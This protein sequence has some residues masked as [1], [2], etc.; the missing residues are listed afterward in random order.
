MVLKAVRDGIGRVNA[1]PAVLVA[2]LAL[3]FLMALPLG[4][5]LRGMIGES[6]GASLA[7]DAAA[8]GVN[9]EWWRV[10]ASQASGLG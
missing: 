4:L 5:V 9:S 1:A 10:F 2:V 6:L 8:D 3:T 7:A